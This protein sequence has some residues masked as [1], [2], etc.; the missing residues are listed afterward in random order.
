[1][2][3]IVLVNLNYRIGVHMNFV[4]STIPALFYSLQSECSCHQGR[5]YGGQW[6]NAAPI[7]KFSC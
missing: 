3:K 6:G 2:L 4:Q 5:S 7:P 1:L